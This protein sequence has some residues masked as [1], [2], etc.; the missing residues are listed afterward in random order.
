MLAEIPVAVHSSSSSKLAVALGMASL[1]LLGLMLWGLRWSQTKMPAP[2]REQPGLVD[3]ALDRGLDFQMRFLPAEQGENFKVNLY[4]HG[5]GVAIADYDGDGDDDAFFLNQLGGNGLFRNRGDGS[6]EKDTR[7]DATLAMADRVCVGAVFGDY[8]NDGDQDLYVTSTRG[9]N[10]LFRNDGDEF[11]DVT[12]EAGVACIAHSQTATFFDYDGDGDL[13]LFVTNT[14]RWTTDEFDEESHY[15]RGEADLW[16]SVYDAKTREENMLFRNDGEGRFSD[17]THAAGLAG[18]GWSGDVAVFDYDED[19]H[20]DLLVTNMFGMS[21]LY[22]NDGQGTFTDVT[23][24]TLGKVSMG[25]IGAKAFDFNNDG[26]LDLLLADMHSD[27]WVGFHDSDLVEPSKKYGSRAGPKGA[28]DPAIAQ[29]DRKVLGRVGT[30][31]ERLVFGNTLFA[32]QGQG[33]FREVSDAAGMET[34]W[35]WGIAVGDFDNDGDVDVFLPS[36]MGHPYFYW[37]SPLMMNDGQGGFTDRAVEE[38]I[39]PPSDGR[40]L[41]DPIGGQRAARS[42][43]CAATADLDGDGRLDLLVNNFNDRAYYY[44]NQFPNRNF[45]QFRLVGTKSNR[46][47]IGAVMKVYCGDRVMVRQVQAAG[48]YL[49]QSSKTLHFGLSDINRIDRAE[50]RW[51]SGLRQTLDSPTINK[52]IEVREPEASVP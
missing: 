51:P 22:H 19:G 47:A 25:A 7:H 40:F 17:V 1:L 21:Q 23:R 6:F 16:I 41:P 37:P 9:G 2:A 36:G 31:Y 18:Q 10:V 14:A 4:D 33:R 39:E 48:G 5:C 43:R 12:Q 11:R 20:P 24:Q 27:M 13:D 3:V 28:L 42:S 52:L 46:D 34:F 32:N 30:D 44:R 8:D 26:R 45:A 35:P 15:Y 50:I 38:G 29:S 49:S